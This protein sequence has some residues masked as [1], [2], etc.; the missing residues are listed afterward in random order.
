[1]FASPAAG[2]LEPL[3]L[4][5]AS[6]TWPLAR[7]VGKLTGVARV[8]NS[9]MVLL[10]GELRASCQQTPMLPDSGL[11]AI[12]GRNWLRIGDAG[13]SLT[14]IGAALQVAPSSSEKRTMM[15][16]S[17]FSLTVSSV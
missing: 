4:V 9:C 2:G 15:S 3:P 8:Q 17:L 13:S 12:R 5:R 10:P 6:P 7:K 14:R 1:M 11:L 16:V